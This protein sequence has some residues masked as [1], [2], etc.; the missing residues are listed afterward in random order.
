MKRIASKPHCA[1]TGLATAA[2]C[3][4]GLVAVATNLAG[5]A[6]SAGERFY[7][8]SETSFGEAHASDAATSATRPGATGPLRIVI[9][10]VTVPDLVDRPQIVTRDS[11][12]RVNVSERNQWAEPLKSAI[13]RIVAARLAETLAPARVAA[14][15]Q[16]SIADPDL[17][18]T[19]DVQRLDA[20]PGGQAVIDALWSVRRS[21]DGMIRPGRT[22]ATRQVD[23]VGY[24]EA[25]RAWS[26]ALQDVSRDI[27]IAARETAAA[28]PREAVRKAR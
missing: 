6:S 21:S 24:E 9:S 14:Y 26:A 22:L 23:G 15:P 25:V 16:S 8:L 27:G 20:I 7:T 12:N 28:A 5:C 13:G 3:F 18:I 11:A 17:R 4:A 2:C 1:W 10:A 19:I